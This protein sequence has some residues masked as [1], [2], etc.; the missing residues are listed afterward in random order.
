MVNKGSIVPVPSF[1]LSSCVSRAV[2]AVP[3]LDLGFDKKT[4]LSA[5][6]I[7]DVKPDS[8]AFRAGI[9]NGQQVVG[10]SVYWD[11]VS[12]PVRL[13]IRSGDAQ[14]TIEYSPKGK[15]VEVP[16][17]HLPTGSSPGGSEVCQFS[18]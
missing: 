17:Y 12:K 4:L 3:P 13:K 10:T 11:D 1:P 6:R 5:H 18:M 16:Q 15:S 9:R 8:A 2:D 14:Q 7:A